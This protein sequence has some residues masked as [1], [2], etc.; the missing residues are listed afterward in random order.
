MQCRQQETHQNRFV[1]KGGATWQLWRSFRPNRSPS[2]AEL[3]DVSLV[4]RVTLR[5]CVTSVSGSVQGSAQTLLAVLACRFRYPQ[6]LLYVMDKK[7][8]VDPPK[9]PMAPA[10]LLLHINRKVERTH[11]PVSNNNSPLWLISQ[12]CSFLLIVS[13]W[14]ERSQGDRKV[15]IFTLGV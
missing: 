1:H 14:C 15:S 12:M 6:G 3:W 7:S 13:H 10:T 11:C 8:P 5:P 4:A 2:S 9:G